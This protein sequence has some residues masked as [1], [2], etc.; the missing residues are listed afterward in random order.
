[1]RAAN[2]RTSHTS[3]WKKSIDGSP[4]GAYFS[5]QASDSL[6]WRGTLFSLV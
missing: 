1:M 5:V 4:G 6:D 2:P 3:Q